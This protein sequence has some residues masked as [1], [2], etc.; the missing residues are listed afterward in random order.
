MAKPKD[1]REWEKIEKQLEKE[2]DA[3]EPEPV[4]KPLNDEI[5]IVKNKD[6]K[7]IPTKIDSKEILTEKQKEQ[8]AEEEKNKGNESFKA[9]EY[10][11]AVIYYTRSLQFIENAASYNNRAMAYLKLEKWDKVIEDCNCV[12]KFD[13]DNV[14]ALMR[15]STALFKKRKFNDALKDLEFVLTK[16]PNNKKA[17]ELLDDVKKSLKVYQKESDEVKSK[18]GKRI[19]IEETDGES[20]EEPAQK[21]QINTQ[22]EE[23]KSKKT[24]KI[25]EVDSDEDENNE[26]HSNVQE[27]SLNVKTEVVSD[28]IEPHQEQKNQENKV[29]ESQIQVDKPLPNEI[30]TLKD[31]A[32]KLFESGQYAEAISFYTQAIDYLKSLTD[33]SF[34]QTL[35]ILYSNRA[36]CRQKI[37]DYKEAINDCDLSLALRDSN[38]KVLFKKASSLEM[39]EKYKLALSEYENIMKL[40]STF[41]QAQDAYNRVKNSLIQQGDYKRNKEL[42]YEELKTKG[43]EYFKQKD[44]EKANEFYTKCIEMDRLNTTGYLNRSICQIKLNRAEKALEDCSYVLNREPVNVK[45]LYRRALAYRMLAKYDNCRLD[46]KQVLNIEPNNQIALQELESLNKQYPEKQEEQSKTAKKVVKQAE[47][48]ELKPVKLKKPVQLPETISNSYEFLQA[49]NSIN[50]Q[51]IQTYCNLIEKIDADKLPKFI[52]SKLDDDMFTRL[53]KIFHHYVFDDLS[54]DREHDGFSLVENR[55]LNKVEILGYMKELT[56]AQRF[57]VIKL[58]L[59]NESKRLIDETLDSIKKNSDSIEQDINLVRKLYGL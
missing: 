12:F 27:S 39:L 20:D 57:D 28:K 48:V 52:G 41:K 15:R 16:E 17:Q 9:K 47:S 40:D 13:K 22:L 49:W 42:T 35:S 26:M 5:P 45:A 8:R 37:G 33:S 2:L 32:N 59:N 1:Y 30:V 51:D 29:S 50:P 23:E 38:I 6:L 36:S 24:I 4:K 19:V 21:I 34:D 11:E 53:I 10:E 44:Y 18:G 43:N 55:K 58:F 31:K 14:K 46:L 56:K 25:K 3:P 54:N 7:K